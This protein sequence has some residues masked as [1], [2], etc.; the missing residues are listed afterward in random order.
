MKNRF[1][2]VDNNVYLNSLYIITLMIYQKESDSIERMM[3]ELYLLKN[4]RVFLDIVAKYDLRIDKS[5]LF[6]FQH[7]NLQSEMLKYS[8]RLHI[9]GFYEALSYLFSKG[10]INYDSKQNSITKTDLFTEINHMELPENIKGLA[11]IINK[12]FD[13]IGTENLKKS[14][15]SIER[16]YYG[17]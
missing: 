4:P 3:L 9:D 14:I 10:L 7:D 15:E 1:F 13:N 17:Q 12:L 8:L 6:G 5:I 16:G 2:D 11:D